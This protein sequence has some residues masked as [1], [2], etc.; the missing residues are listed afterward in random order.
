[1]NVN[2]VDVRYKVGDM[3]SRDLLR[4][5]EAAYWVDGTDAQW[6][7]RVGEACRPALDEGFG[8]CVFQFQHQLGS[9]PQILRAAK[10]AIPEPLSALYGEVFRR[11]DPTVQVRPFTHG[12]C[13]T[14]SQMMGQREEFRDNE[15]MKR[16]VHQFGMYDSL[17]ITA[18][19][20]S[21]SGCGIHSGRPAVGW[22]SRSF[23]EHWARVATHLAA[24]VR[25]RRRMQ[26]ASE[27]AP[28][29]A[30]LEANGKVLHAEG[31]A[32]EPAAMDQLRRA[33]LAV[34]NA[35]GPAGHSDV[36]TRLTAWQ[37]L[38]D[39]RWSLLDQFE[40]DG[41]R[42]IV[43]RENA[44]RPPGPA[45]LTQRERQVLGYAAVGHDNKVIAY[46]L[47]IAHATVK[48]LMARAATKLGVR[49]RSEVISAYLNACGAAPAAP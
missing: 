4:I 18:A 36:M 9:P 3:G 41:R 40:S 25:L 10:V 42:F 2:A 7:E 14:G 44:P 46:D 5:V 24:G 43:A 33:V 6:L 48:V 1:M 49:S 16:H 22:V 17:W 19:E 8:L 12:P 35:R 11:M 31:P 47:G 37:G 29:E 20:P 23:R 27:P 30:V 45:A 38:V 34:E 26:S 13:T 39:A 21:G 32:T 15:H 28:V